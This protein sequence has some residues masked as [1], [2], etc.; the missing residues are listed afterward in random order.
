MNTTILLLR[1]QDSVQGYPNPNG[2]YP[3]TVLTPPG[4]PTLG[5]SLDTA[6][7]PIDHDVNH[8]YNTMLTAD[9]TLPSSPVNSDIGDGADV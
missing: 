6:T 1:T 8:Y 4:T 7:T 2:D 5:S 3:Q 9:M